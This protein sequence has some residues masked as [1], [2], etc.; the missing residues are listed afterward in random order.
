MMDQRAFLAGMAGGLLP[1][2]LCAEAQQAKVARVGFLVSQSVTAESLAAFRK[3]LRDLGCSA[4]G[5]AALS[6]ARRQGV[7][8]QRDGRVAELL[9]LALRL[10][11][12]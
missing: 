3:G 5:R 12:R 6:R 8:K 9:R 1:A 10:V 11:G 2:A 7:L 4:R